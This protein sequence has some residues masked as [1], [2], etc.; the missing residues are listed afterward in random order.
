[1]KRKLVV[2]I[3]LAAVGVSLISTGAFV[4]TP[5]DG[6]ELT[7]SDGPNS[8]YAVADDDGKLKIDLSEQ[9]QRLAEN[10]TRVTS[11]SITTVEGIFTVRHNGT[12]GPA[13]V[14]IETDIDDV[15]FVRG[16]ESPASI[17]GEENSVLLAPGD[18]RHVG[19]VVDTT[20]D[21]D[22]EEIE[23]F[24]LHAAWMDEETTPDTG[25]EK[26][27]GPDP[28]DND[29][30]TDGPGAEEDGETNADNSDEAEQR[31]DQTGES[32]VHDTAG[33]ERAEQYGDANTS[34]QTPAADD[35]AGNQSDDGAVTQPGASDGGSQGGTSATLSVDEPRGSL[36]SSSF[37]LLLVVILLCC[38]VYALVRYRMSVTGAE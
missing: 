22:V 34:N 23:A 3:A 12:A 30:T 38:A 1:M 32:D 31:N 19:I 27:T 18:E 24:T 20:G 25:T 13:K 26:P 10:A 8:V 2:V 29:G 4:D 6:I 33:D 36:L 16:M 5:T 14:W 17:D 7:P 21:H 9:N 15:E 28:T 35:L 11:N 37:P